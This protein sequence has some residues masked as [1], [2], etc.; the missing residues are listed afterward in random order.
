MESVMRWLSLSI[1]V[2]HTVK[3]KGEAKPRQQTIDLSQMAVPLQMAQEKKQ[4]ALGSPEMST[5]ETEPPIKYITAGTWPD[6]SVFPKWHPIPYT[7]VQYIE[8][9]C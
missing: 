1:S 3:E 4:Q 6:H 8:Q 5:V 9:G 7:V 2:A